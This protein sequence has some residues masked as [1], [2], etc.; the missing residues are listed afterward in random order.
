[1]RKMRERRG[2]ER[3]DKFACRAAILVFFTTIGYAQATF[4]DAPPKL[5]PA[6]AYS[7]MGAPTATAPGVVVSENPPLAASADATSERKFEAYVTGYGFWD[8]TPPGSAVISHPVIH[9]RAGGTGTYDDPVTVAVGHMISGG[10]DTLD[11]PA[12]TL[13]YFPFLKKYA[14][15]EDTCGDGGRPQ[16][17]PCHVGYRGKPWLDV[18]LGK[19]TSRA[20]SERCMN[21]ITGV[22]VVIQDPA[23]TY[24]VLA[25]EIVGQCSLH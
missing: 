7:V 9:K 15:V 13:F 3:P 24:P 23:T 2:D 25:G 6:A 21:R 17:G 1:M 20:R 11:F 8:N 22:H 12:G 14:I 10:R 5:G 19:G 4:A 18:Y 16:D